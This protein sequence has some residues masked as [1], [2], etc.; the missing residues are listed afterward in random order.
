VTRICTAALV[1][2]SPPHGLGGLNVPKQHPPQR[3]D[4]EPDGQIVSLGLKLRLLEASNEEAIESAFATLREG[5]FDALMIG[6]DPVFDVHRDKLIALV[7]AAG[8]SAISQFPV[9]MASVKRRI[10]GDPACM[11]RQ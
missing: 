1:D 9:L 4:E 10:L 6:S 7:A 5:K 2:R 3:P 11:G 8:I